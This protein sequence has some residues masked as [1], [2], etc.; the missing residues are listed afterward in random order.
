MVDI[1]SSTILNSRAIQW[2][3]QSLFYYTDDGWHYV[4]DNFE[5]PCNSVKKSNPYSITQMMVDITSSTILNSRA[6]QLKN[7]ISI[8]NFTNTVMKNV[9]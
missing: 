4:I 1:T 3:I 8:W 9:K 2:K 5:F 7:P 6:I